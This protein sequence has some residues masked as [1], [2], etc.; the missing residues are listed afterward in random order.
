MDV[1]GLKLSELNGNNHLLHDRQSH[2]DWLDSINLTW[3]EEAR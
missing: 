3:N 2:I 1:T